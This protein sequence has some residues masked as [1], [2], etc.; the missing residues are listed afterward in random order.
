MNNINKILKLK[1]FSIN[2]KNKYKILLN[3]IIDLNLH[4]FNK[5]KEYA[6]ILKFFNYD[7][8]K[9]YSLNELP[10]LP[11]RIFK[12]IDIF[13]VKEKDIVNRLTSSGTSGQNL[14]KIY[15][16]RENSLNQV[17]V[18]S[19]IVSDSIGDTRLPLL[20]IDSKNC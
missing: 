5:C 13:S 3:T 7:K 14:S 20:F 17:R 16:D 4:H 2:K 10:F 15:L 8:K 19:N 9:N 6:N 1:P 18:L 12:S 11:V